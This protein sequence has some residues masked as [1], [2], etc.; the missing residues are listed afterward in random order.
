VTDD[1]DVAD[2]PWLDC[3]HLRVLLLIAWV[4]G[5]MLVPRRQQ[6]A[7]GSTSSVRGGAPG[8]GAPQAGQNP[9]SSGLSRPHCAHVGTPRVYDGI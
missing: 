3:G 5:G 1:G 6:G 2:L 7:L 9:N 4:L 8:R